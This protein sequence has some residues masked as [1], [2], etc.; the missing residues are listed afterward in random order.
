VTKND[1]KNNWWLDTGRKGASFVN[2]ARTT[3]DDLYRISFL[4]GKDQPVEILPGK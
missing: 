4:G 1:L 3:I 2:K